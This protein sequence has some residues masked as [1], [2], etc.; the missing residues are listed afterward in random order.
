MIRKDGS[1]QVLSPNI[2]DRDI[3]WDKDD[4][5]PL[6]AGL[7]GIIG[8]GRRTRPVFFN[9]DAFQDW[10][11]KQGTA[12]ATAAPKVGPDGG[13]SSSMYAIEA[14]LD[15]WI[16]G[17]TKLILEQLRQWAPMKHDT[18][19]KG[20]LALALSGW[21]EKAGGAT[22]KSTIEKALPEKLNKALALIK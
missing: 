13:R 7:D 20:R 10:L 4:V 5:A 15:R 11:A 14:E 3:L 19:S 8:P 2:W 9:A 1:N 12:A 16:G 21:S 6:L 17:K 18:R 22:A